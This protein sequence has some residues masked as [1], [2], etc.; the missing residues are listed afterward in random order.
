MWTCAQNPNMTDE[1]LSIRGSMT[2]FEL[3]RQFSEKFGLSAQI[4]RKSGNLWLDTTRTNFLTL[5]EQDDHGREIS[6]DHLTNGAN[7]RSSGHRR[8]YGQ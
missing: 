4:L 2:V 8:S 5:K 1:D 3:E 7:I 6:P